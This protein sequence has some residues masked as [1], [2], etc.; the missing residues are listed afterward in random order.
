VT[1][2]IADGNARLVVQDSGPGLTEQDLAHLF[3]P[4][5]RG[6]PARTRDTG[7]GL[8]LALARAVV[9]LHGGRIRAGNA[10]SG[11]ARFEIEFPLAPH[12]E[13]AR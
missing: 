10:P 7:G 3:Q 11:G 5:Y 12:H 8:G 13:R 1:T 9:D 4:F 2:D 6:D